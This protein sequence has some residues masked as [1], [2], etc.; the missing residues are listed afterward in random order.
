[1]FS[2]VHGLGGQRVQ[3]SKESNNWISS[4]GKMTKSTLY[5]HSY[6]PDGLVVNLTDSQPDLFDPRRLQRGAHRAEEGLMRIIFDSPRKHFFEK[7]SG[8]K[9]QTHKNSKNN[10]G[11]KVVNQVEKQ[12]PPK[13][14][15]VVNSQFFSTNELWR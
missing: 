5:E 4:M 2:G 1:M 9:W 3:K 8:P 6:W 7:Q 14:N 13:K 15:K 10:F 11:T 12:I